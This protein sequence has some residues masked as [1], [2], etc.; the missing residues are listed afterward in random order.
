MYLSAGAALA[1]A[2]IV[3]HSRTRAS[4]FTLARDASRLAHA[5]RSALYG[6]IDGQ[7]KDDLRE[8]Q[9]ALR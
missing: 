7:G 4:D 8:V 9:A 2:S 1:V 3:G 5:Y 6:D